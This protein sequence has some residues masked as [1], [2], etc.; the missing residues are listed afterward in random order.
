MYNIGQISLVN[1][2]WGKIQCIPLFP[3]FTHLE[4]SSN[5]PLFNT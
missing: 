5:T 4:L 2:L 1:N 3:S